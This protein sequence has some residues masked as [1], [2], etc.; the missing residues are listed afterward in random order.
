MNKEHEKGLVNQ[1][2]SNRMNAC[3]KLQLVLI[4]QQAQQILPASLLLS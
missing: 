1:A 3:I 2:F 4:P